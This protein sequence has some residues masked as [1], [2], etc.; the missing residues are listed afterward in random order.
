MNYGPGTP[1]RNNNNN[2][3]NNVNIEENLLDS[4]AP[5][6][7]QSD[8]NDE[9]NT[10]QRQSPMSV[11]TIIRE[12]SKSFSEAIKDIFQKTP[13][14]DRTAPHVSGVIVSPAQG[15]TSPRD[16]LV[17][18][19][20]LSTPLNSSQSSQ[21]SETGQ[22]PLSHY[23]HAPTTDDLLVRVPSWSICAVCNELLK[24]PR[25]LPGCGHIFCGPCLEQVWTSGQA[26]SN[27]CPLCRDVMKFP[28]GGPKELPVNQEIVEAIEVLPVRCRWGVRL[29]TESD[30]VSSAD[31]IEFN[32][33]VPGGA[34]RVDEGDFFLDLN[35]FWVPDTDGCPAI[36]PVSELKSHVENCLYEL[37]D[38][39]NRGCASKIRKKDVQSHD[40]VCAFK[41]ITCPLCSTHYL[42]Q[43]SAEHSAHC[44][45]ERI[46]CPNNC[47]ATFRRK[48][49]KQH[50]QRECPL[51]KVYC[52]HKE[53]GCEYRGNRSELGTHLRESCRYEPIKKFLE[54]NQQQYDKLEQKMRKQHELIV[55][56]QRM[57]V[58][59]S[60]EIKWL[61]QQQ[62]FASDQS[63]H[64]SHHGSLPNYRRFTP[65]EQEDGFNLLN[66][67]L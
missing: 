61:K 55:K 4:T 45:E 6:P 12:R 2:S 39:P 65:D 22:S 19:T 42:Q 16:I 15:A 54:I 3:N 24:L 13:V 8:A 27:Y 7:I 67:S 57:V 58:Q 9:S 30:D 18:P 38:C 40:T 23:L 37:V 21:P 32:W 50:L 66:T 14:N 60:E 64:S 17:A 51:V 52:L 29:R 46:T 11:L 62:Q 36:V 33:P 59:Q 56:L 31:R 28:K 63:A 49:L 26:H 44:P 25:S 35:D 43:Y 34:P 53:Y 47:E 41:V 10:N 48:Q 20:S 1:T 5:I